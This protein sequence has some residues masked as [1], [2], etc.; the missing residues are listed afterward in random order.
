MPDLFAYGGLTR[1][2]VMERLLGRLPPYRPAVLYNH[3]RVL[4]EETGFFRVV[5]SQGS[6]VDGLLYEGLSEA[7][8][9]KLDEYEEVGR[10]LYRRERAEVRVGNLRRSAWIYQ[11][12]GTGSPGPG[13]PG[14]A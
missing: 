5:P 8:L 10:G 14:K 12:P 11:G 7:E 13:H 9:A 4:D 3:R 6:K 2:E 1:P